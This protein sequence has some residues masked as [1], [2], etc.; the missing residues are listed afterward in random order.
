MRNVEIFYSLG[1]DGTFYVGIRKLF[2]FAASST[3]KVMMYVCVVCFFKLS[4]VISELMFDDQF[5]IQQQIYI[6]V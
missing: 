2:Y 4:D 3:D 1:L 5:T 6:I